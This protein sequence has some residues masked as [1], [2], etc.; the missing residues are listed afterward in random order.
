ME[1]SSAPTLLETPLHGWHKSKGAKLADFGGWE[2]PIEYGNYLNKLG[3]KGGVLA[4][5]T[6]VREKVGLF[7]VSHLGKI[8]IKGAD[9]IKFLNQLLTNDL[10]K[11]NDGQAQYNMICNKAG[12]V[13]DDLI[14]YRRNSEDLLLIPNASNCQQVYETLQENN[15]DNLSI[16][17]V[18]QKYAVIALQ[19]PSTNEVLST[20]NIKLEL[21]YMS[22]SVISIPNHP[23]LGQVIV[24]RTGY[25]GEYGFEFLPLWE[26]CQAFWN[27]LEGAVLDAG[28]RVCGLGSR[29]TLRTEMGYPLHGHELSLEISPLQ[30]N[31]GWAVALTKGDFLGS[32]SLLDEKTKGVP[33]I[34]R[35][36]LVLDKAIPRAEMVV[37]NNSNDACGVVTSGTFSPTL[38]QGIALALLDPKVAIGDLVEID[39]RDRTSSA[40]V[41]KPPFVPSH[42]R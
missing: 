24:C 20:L 30:A 41:V 34:L 23:E 35:G 37:R 39:V 18:H 31:A 40:K 1:N 25:T 15:K 19:G 11:I 38:K 22:F 4:E 32:Q 21:D 3:E 10:E 2:M 17:N 29:D 5:H 9:A 13:I 8:E 28:G 6:S 27:L 7:D 33:R 26:N 36:L 16:T 42:V 14:V 12:G